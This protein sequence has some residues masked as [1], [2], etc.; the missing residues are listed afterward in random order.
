M[1]IF[2]ALKSDNVE[3]LESHYVVG[4]WLMEC[5]YAQWVP[6]EGQG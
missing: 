5:T 3:T 4:D 2:S 6:K 1:N